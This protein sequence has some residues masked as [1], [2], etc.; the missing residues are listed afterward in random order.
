[1][2]Q[3]E[4][5]K[6]TFTGRTLSGKTLGV[7]GFGSV[8]QEVSNREN[9]SVLYTSAHRIPCAHVYWRRF[10]RRKTARDALAWLLGGNRYLL[11]S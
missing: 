8:G 10:E 9:R 1:M 4:W 11:R 6:K 2:R 3:G 5:A 7:V